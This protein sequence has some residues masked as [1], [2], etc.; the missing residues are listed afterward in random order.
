MAFVP[1]EQ[2]P[3]TT[4]RFVPDERRAAPKAPES[5]GLMRPIFAIGDLL[6][7]AAYKA[8]SGTTDLATSLGLSPESAAKFGLAANVGVQAIPTFGAGSVAKSAAPLLEGA[9]NRL[10]QSALKPTLENLKNGNAA[11]AISTMLDEGLNATSGGVQAIRS[12]IG[13]LNTEI[14]SAIANSPATVDKGA[15]AS[16]LYDTLKKFSMQVN[17]Q[18]DVK[19]VE[20]AWNSFLDHPLLQGKTTMPVQTAQDMK[21]ATYRSLGDKAYGELSG[22]SEEAQKQLARGLKE[23]IATA[24]P[25]VAGLNKKESDLINALQITERRALM[26]GNKNLGGLALLTHSPATFAAF[27]A[28][29][30][31]LF[32]SLVARML[33]SGS[34]AIPQAAGTAAGATLGSQL[35]RPPKE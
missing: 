11:R 24:V 27:M 31:A 30:S 25:Q 20:S 10:M 5:Y 9:G 22:A 19:A 8:G 14:A 33:S 7:K 34:E 21:Q 6:D 35:G 28:D 26:D 23:E 13:Q 18:A 29:K 17:P 2:A 32:K 16:R 4:G 3:E 1:D 12:K 15:V